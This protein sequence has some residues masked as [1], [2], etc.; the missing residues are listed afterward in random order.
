MSIS[1]HKEGA[2]AQILALGDLSSQDDQIELLE[3]INSATGSKTEV[4][5]YDALVLSSDIIKALN[6][7]KLRVHT[8]H[9]QLSHS[10]HRLGISYKNIPI[11]KQG[12]KTTTFKVLALGG[13]VSDIPDIV[14][15]ISSLS[16]S[17]MSLFIVLADCETDTEALDDL[18]KAKTEYSLLMPHHRM[19]VKPATIYIAPPSFNMRVHDGIIYLGCDHKLHGTRPS[20]DVLFESLAYEYQA[21]L[22]AAILTGT[23]DDGLESIPL[24]LDK[25]A[26]VLVESENLSEVKEFSFSTKS[27]NA[28][29]THYVLPRIGIQSFF[30]SAVLKEKPPEHNTVK[31]LLKAVKKQYGYDFSDYQEG[32]INRRIEMLKK[33][34]GTSDFFTLQRN[35]LINQASFE[36]L[37]YLL[38][39]N[40]TTFF[41]E[42]GQLCY[43]RQTI[44]PSLASFSRIN[45]WIAGCS[46]GKEAYSIAIILKELGLLD[47]AMIYATDINPIILNEAKNGLYATDKIK[48]YEENYHLSG[49]GNTFSD[50]IERHGDFCEIKSEIREKVHF[51]H[52][53]L[54]DDDVFNEF[55]LVLCRNVIIYF[56]NQLQ[57]QVMQL[58]S[59]SLH[60]GGFLA[61]GSKE[62]I[63]LGEGQQYFKTKNNQQKVYQ[64][65]N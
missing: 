17:D 28:E 30:S 62:A 41:R 59:R 65:M 33:N 57:K 54:V 11:I 38:S 21:N 44:L 5:F 7:A 2:K 64:W 45:I 27:G 39:I 13:M 35:V 49:G 3:A 46:S 58:F 9:S 31:L 63:T 29:K 43:L 53:S 10:L 60:R 22:M 50:Y 61:L 1:H 24:L 48:E 16:L 23:N 15:L 34:L 4:L 55:Q 6:N 37:F 20:I 12:E 32:V 56:S 8:Y 42:P 18:L 19:T 51:F 40:V 52:H 26:T 47:R 14:K 25:N 36:Q